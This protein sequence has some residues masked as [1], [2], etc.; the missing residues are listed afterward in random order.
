MSKR[1]SILLV[2]AL[3]VVL[4]MS[5]FAAA[6]G[7]DDET[8]TTAGATETRRRHRDDAGATETTAAASGDAIK[9]G[10]DEGFTGF[11]A[12][13]TELAEKGILTALD[14]MGNQW[15]GRPLEYLKEDNGSDPVVAVD[16]M[17]KLVESDN[18]N[19][20]VGPIFS[21]SAK[22]VS[23]FWASRPASP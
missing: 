7:G 2:L 15:E 8:A 9:F 18:I 6:C 23:D 4:L 11:M 22:A 5:L 12:Y 13:D 20:S 1:T 19:T 16:K 17:R 21:P 14:M 3:G 10:F